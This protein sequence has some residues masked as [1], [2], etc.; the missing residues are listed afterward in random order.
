M[1]L[2]AAKAS[3]ARFCTAPRRS[4]SNN[5][6]SGTWK[7]C[8]GRMS[9]RWRCVRSRSRCDMTAPMRIHRALARAGVAS[10]RKAETLIRAGRVSV[11]GMPAAIGQVVDLAKDRVAVDGSLVRLQLPEETWLVLNKPA[12]VMTTR[13][14]P[15]GRKTVFELV[16]DR[17]GLTYVG[18]LDLLT[19]GVL[20][21]T[22]D[23][24][25]AHR[26]T[27]PSSEVERVYEAT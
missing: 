18:R 5:L 16:E 8:P 24:D 3:G 19:E 7:R 4:S 10:R 14:D 12:G 27:H 26:L 17:P 6:R 1:S 2:R 22:T 23:G 11:N 21:L 9:S 15:E 20:L 25:A 13:R